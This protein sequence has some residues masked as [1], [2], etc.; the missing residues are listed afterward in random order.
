M[1]ASASPI[2][3]DRFTS[4]DTLALTR[5]VRSMGRAWL[6]KVFDL[7]SGG[8]LFA[9]RR[10]G[11]GRQE[12]KVRPGVYGALL[13]DRNPHA[14]EPGP[15]SRELRRWLTGAQ[16]HGIQQAGG[17]RYFEIELT[18][19]DVAGKLTLVIELFGTGN[20]LLARDDQ[21]VVVSHSRTWAHRSVR[22]GVPYQRPPARRDPWTASM[23]EL[24]ATL[25]ASRTDRASTLAARL[26]LGGP[27]TEEVLARARVAGSE[28]APTDLARAATEIH[29]ALAGL[30]GEVGDQPRGY[31]Y[32]RNEVAIDVEPFRAVR[33]SEDPGVEV[34]EFA[35]FSEAAE[36]Y[37]SSL[38]P[39][40]AISVAKV[41]AMAEVERQRDQQAEAVRTL[42][43]DSRRLTAE[44]ERIYTHYAE[45]EEEL[46]K[47]LEADPDGSAA[48]VVELDGAPTRL[49]RGRSL[50]ESAQAIYEE[51]KRVQLKLAGAR[52]ALAATEHRLQGPPPIDGPHASTSSKA[53]PVGTGRK[54]WFERYRWFLSSEGAIVI[55]GRDAAS[56]DLVVRRYLKAGDRYVHADI[57]GAPSVIVKHPEPG[58]DPV[59]ETTLREAAQFGVA[60]SKA[61][62]AGL[63]AGDAFW[64]EADQVS[65]AAATGEFVARG[66]WVIHGRKNVIRDLPLELGLGMVSVQGAE[67]WTAAPRS[68]VERWGKVRFLL[69]PGEERERLARER[70]LTESLG[71]PSSL[72]QGL[73]PAG[74]L[75]VRRA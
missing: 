25:G 32:R 18:R 27:V 65:K 31:L 46:A 59:T 38:A 20:I 15:L 60:F 21:L 11:A 52:E 47:S 61:W 62:R 37:F 1:S 24:E 73:L 6:D 51:A 33:W 10:A 22:V 30:L 34:V 49:I 57:H 63:A 29:A 14:E 66:A 74:G 70:E 40:D 9:F 41:S 35:T 68:S 19:G 53:S 7:P 4:L 71:I 17:E 44:A 3:K 58:Q 56:N 50:T 69:T 55:G 5:E 8:L 64:V 75:T 48:I 72:L 36:D 2:L 42:A 43:D 16:L 13:S 26:A 28:P 39:P 54:L 23:A 45:A 12:L 67:R